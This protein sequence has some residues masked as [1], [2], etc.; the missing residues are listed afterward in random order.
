M[1]DNTNV[2][3]IYGVG[4]NVQKGELYKGATKLSGS[5]S[6]FSSIDKLVHAKKRRILAPAF[7]EKALATMQTYVLDQI[8]IFIDT[9]SGAKSG[10]DG[11]F[12]GDMSLWCN[13]LTFDIMGDLSFGK[14]FGMLTNED[15]RGIPTLIDQNVYRQHIVSL[16]RRCLPCFSTIEIY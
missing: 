7:T 14:Q 9:L 4:H 8:D 16:I 13:Y 2:P 6:T 5:V 12:K 15:M 10:M 11:G 1:S 3:D